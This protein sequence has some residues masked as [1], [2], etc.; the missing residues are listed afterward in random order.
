MGSGL[1]SFAAILVVLIASVMTTDLASAHGGGLDRNGCHHNNR[2]G[3]Y[4]CHR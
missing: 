3:D 1:K 2:T 4:H